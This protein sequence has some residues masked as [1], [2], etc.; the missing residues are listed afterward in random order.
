[1][2]NAARISLVASLVTCLLI[3]TTRAATLLFESGFESP[4]VV[5]P[6]VAEGN[7]WWSYIGGG[8][9]GY[10]WRGD[11]PGSTAV[12]FQYLV[13]ANKDINEFV[14]T[15]I[16]N[17]QGR[18][19]SNESTMALYQEVMQDDPDFTATTRNQSNIHN[20]NPSA[21]TA[22]SPAFNSLYTRYWVK[23]QEDL[24]DHLTW[25]QMMEWRSGI[26]DY[27]W[28]VYVY[29][30]SAGVPHWHVEAQRGV[31]GDSP[32]DWSVSNTTVPVP[33]GR[34]F[35]FEAFW[36]GSAGEDGK[37]Q[38]AIDG[39]VIANRTGRT[40][41]DTSRDSQFNL[42]KVYGGTG[43]RYQWIDDVDI[44]DAPPCGEFPCSSEDVTPRETTPPAAPRNVIVR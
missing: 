39:Q 40:R 8:D 2:W 16:E 3:P 27:R 25:R 37:V 18:G 21:S 41:L 28:S 5:D 19:R 6:P 34:W 33:I 7:Q 11:L 17:T 23:F 31:L 4:V 9:R 42:F 30:N 1:M 32:R 12:R 35:L 22:I 29:K 24:V 36:N 38:I 43:L 15:S 26:G 10:V 44:W 13:G 20:T 14:H